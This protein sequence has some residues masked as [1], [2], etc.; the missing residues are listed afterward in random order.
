MRGGRG[1][2]WRTRRSRR[3]AFI[4]DR[5]EKRRAVSHGCSLHRTVVH[6]NSK[7]LTQYAARTALH[8]RT[9]PDQT[10]KALQ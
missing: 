1:G 7:A 5:S 10:K 8:T 3:S 2:G 4:L 6:H 9:R